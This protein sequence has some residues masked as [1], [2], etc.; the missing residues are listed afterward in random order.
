[1]RGRDDVVLITA[2]MGFSVFEELQN[3]FSERFMNTGVTEQS[4]VGIAAGLALS[5]YRVFFYTLAPFA[6]MRC[7]EQI[8]VD[9]AMQKAGVIIVGVGAGFGFGQL[10]PTHH[11]IEDIAIMRS[12]PG[13]TVVCPGDPAETRAA[14]KA[15]ARMKGP[16]YLR[17]GKK[18]E[19]E[20]HTGRVSF[21]LGKI[22]PVE[23][24][25]GSECTL[26]GTGNMVRT[27]VDTAALLRNKGVK[28]AVVSVPT[29]KPLD[30]AG[31]VSYANGARVAATLEEHSIIGG[32]GSAVAEVLAENNGTVENFMRFGVHDVFTFRA[33]SQEYLRRQHGL[34]PEQIAGRILQTFK[35]R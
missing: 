7:F 12:I 9:V 1:M 16:A 31:I 5:G 3:E 34:L 17:I 30:I 11:A 26:F 10:G 28:A 20:V 29:V 25:A 18:G 14:T 22:I 33:G 13:M 24:G 19:P 35:K 15:L 6:T 2:D 21:S 23:G 27:A 4:S 32:L 8:R